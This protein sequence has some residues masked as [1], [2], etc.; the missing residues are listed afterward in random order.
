MHLLTDCPIVLRIYI[1][2]Y[3]DRDYVLIKDR[4]VKVTEWT[5][6]RDMTYILDPQRVTTPTGF[7]LIGTLTAFLHVPST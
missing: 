4:Q 2:S 3:F 6:K 5:M 1:I 7:G